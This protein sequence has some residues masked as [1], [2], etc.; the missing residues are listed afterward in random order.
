MYL[1]EILVLSQLFVPLWMTQLGKI[2]TIRC[3]C[4]RFSVCLVIFARG[5]DWKYPAVVVLSGMQLSC[6]TSWYPEILNEIQPQIQEPCRGVWGDMGMGK[7][8]RLLS[9]LLLLHCFPWEPF[10]G[11]TLLCR[12]GSTAPARLACTRT[13][14]VA[15]NCPYLG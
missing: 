9:S 15:T 14:C 13:L 10:W 2:L 8:L 3:S 12:G 11:P 7:G 4:R 5:L 1:R 6:E